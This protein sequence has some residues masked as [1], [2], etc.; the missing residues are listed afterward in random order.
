EG[1]LFLHRKGYASLHELLFGMFGK[2]REK[3]RVGQKPGK[4]ANTLLWANK[5]YKTLWQN[6]YFPDDAVVWQRPVFQSAVELLEK[7][8]FDRLITVSL[9]FSC[10]MVGWKLKQRFPAVHWT[11]DI[12]D[13]FS[14][15]AQP[16]NNW[17]ARSRQ[18]EKTV[19]ETADTTVVTTPA[20]RELYAAEFGH[21]AV[22]KMRV[23]PPLLDPPWQKN[24]TPSVQDGVLRLGYFG[25]FYKGVR[26]P[27]PLFDL[28]DKMLHQGR[29]FELHWHGNVPPEAWEE[30]G[31][32]PFLKVHGLQS[33]DTVRNAM[34]CMDV[35]VNVGNKTLW[36]LP[37]KA[38]EYYASGKPV[39]HLAVVEGDAFERFFEG[40]GRLV[41][42]LVDFSSL[43]IALPNAT[44]F[45]V[46]SVSEVYL[47]KVWHRNR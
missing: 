30:I 19:L 32:R 31:T 16:L 34:M 42:D 39:L 37:S 2:T 11:A 5:L 17:S 25:A 38:V 15:Q 7:N 27:G 3:G 47:S 29:P 21:K 40:T 1:N 23:A 35:L 20:T 43:K 36:Q 44:M 9:P 45:E 26:D 4:P 8:A 6:L 14:L 28:Y 41:R 13:P 12:G 24:S 46:A 18:W 22:E 33:R 10:H